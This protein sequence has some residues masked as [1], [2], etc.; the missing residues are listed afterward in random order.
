[1]TE[2]TPI[3]PLMAFTGQTAIAKGS[4]AALRQLQDHCDR[5][6]ALNGGRDGWHVYGEPG[7]R[8]IRKRSEAPRDYGQPR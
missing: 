4:D 3:N 2:R 7:S 1:M 8:T 6:N 5:L